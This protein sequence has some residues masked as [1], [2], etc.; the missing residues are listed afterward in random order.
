VTSQ[1]YE[2]IKVKQR[3]AKLTARHSLGEVL[4]GRA[5]ALAPEEVR[6][7]F[8]YD[9]ALVAAEHPGLRT[10]AVTQI[11]PLLQSGTL[12]LLGWEGTPERIEA[13]LS[14]YVTGPVTVGE[15]AELLER[16]SVSTEQLYTANLP[17][18]T[19]HVDR[20]EAG[21]GED[22]PVGYGYAILQEPAPEL[23]DA[24]GHYKP[25]PWRLEDC[26]RVSVVEGSW[27]NQGMSLGEVLRHAHEAI[28][29]RLQRFFAMQTVVETVSESLGSG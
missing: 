19:A 22:E 26:S 27:G 18:W 4:D 29:Q 11:T 12:Q 17:E 13:L 7:Q 25:S 21:Y 14:R 28:R 10:Q 3:A 6:A 24:Q 20:V 23:L 15:S 9:P 8:F 16:A 1:Q 2:A 5:Y